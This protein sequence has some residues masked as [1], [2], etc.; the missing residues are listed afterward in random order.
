MKSEALKSHSVFRS[1]KIS[2]TTEWNVRAQNRLYHYAQA[3]A[4][5]SDDA[6][7][8]ALKH[9]GAGFESASDSSGSDIEWS[10]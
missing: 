4:E 7:T 2:L 5:R 8:L 10:L 9:M 6:S 3:R 1:N